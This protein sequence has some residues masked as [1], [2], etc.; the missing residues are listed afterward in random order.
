MASICRT[1]V[2]D[3]DALSRLQLAAYELMENVVKY[4]SQG[5]GEFQLQLDAG[6]QGLPYRAHDP[7]QAA[8]RTARSWRVA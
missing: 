6:A 2:S 4:T 1:Y 5:D 7:E 8:A 3:A